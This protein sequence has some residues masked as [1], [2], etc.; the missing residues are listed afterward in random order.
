[1]KY[2]FLCIR[3]RSLCNV[4]YPDYCLPQL[5][6]RHHLTFVTA[7]ASLPARYVRSEVSTQ[8]YFT[9]FPHHLIFFFNLF[10]YYLYDIA[11]H[12]GV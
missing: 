4:F 9:I 6:M 8:Y 2:F 3:S 5:Q 12:I 1:M 10:I 7:L 11:V